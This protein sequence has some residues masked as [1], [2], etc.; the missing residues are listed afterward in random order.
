M[1]SETTKVNSVNETQEIENAYQE[2]RIM[3]EVNKN[4][5]DEFLQDHE[6]KGL[7]NN[8]VGNE[9]SAVIQV[10]KFTTHFNENKRGGKPSI[11]LSDKMVTKLKRKADNSRKA[12]KELSML[13]L[14]QIELTHIAPL[15]NA[16]LSESYTYYLTQFGFVVW[17]LPL[18]PVVSVF[19][20]LFNLVHVYFYQI[21]FS[22]LIKTG[23]YYVEEDIGIWAFLLDLIA[24][25]GVGINGW[26]LSKQSLL[27]GN[28]GTDWGSGRVLVFTGGALVAGWM[29]R[30]FGGFGFNG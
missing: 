26:I 30:R 11:L 25:S 19:V 15:Q 6:N 1:A 3:P 5:H 4:P 10:Q 9:G 14:S 2:D 13:S 17:F 22:T 18:W 20:F 24:F 8:S 28:T 7:A 21:E 16:L 27:V 29:I 12:N 23:K